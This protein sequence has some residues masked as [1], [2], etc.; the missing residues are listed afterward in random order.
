MIDWLQQSCDPYVVII[1]LTLMP[2]LELRASIPFGILLAHKPWWSVFA[3]AVA[4]N[5]VLGPILYLLLDRCLHLALRVRLLDRIWQRVIVRNQAKIHAKI[6]RYGVLGLGLFIG[7][8]LPGSGVYSGAA[9][10]YLLGMGHRDFLK[11]TV[12]GV[13]IAGVVVLLF[14]LFFSESLPLLRRLFIKT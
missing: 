1:L 6:E 13:V 9:G 11:A 14:T 2:A 7:V 3:V 8:P 12:I 5:I 4:T 10:G